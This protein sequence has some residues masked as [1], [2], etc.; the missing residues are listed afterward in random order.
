MFEHLEAM[1]IIVGCQ[2]SGT[3]LLGQIFGARPDA[4][5]IDE[6]DGLYQWFDL[7]AR[8]EPQTRSEVSNILSRAGRK[9]LS[10][11]Q[12]LVRDEEHSWSLAPQIRYLVLKAPNLSY[13]YRQIARMQLN[14]FLIY[15]KRDPRSVVASMMRLEGIDFVGN[16]LKLLAQHEDLMKQFADA[17][18]IAADE[19][20]PGW[21]RKSMIWK[22]KSHL[23]SRYREFGLPFVTLA[24]EQLV[25]DPE[26]ALRKIC[27]VS[28]IPFDQSMLTHERFYKG[29]GPGNTARDRSIDTR[30]LNHWKNQLTREREEAIVNLIGDEMRTLGYLT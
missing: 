10:S 15:P 12:K 17:V 6:E 8:E 13:S 14:S 3:T 11:S 19:S 4:F 18:A 29:F 25:A 30:S 28:N 21:V 22:V 16:Q 7:Y 20:Q 23:D 26:S 2:R 1:V 9:Y 5:L 24:Y 27:E